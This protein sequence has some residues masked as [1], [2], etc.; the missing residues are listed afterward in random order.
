MG[1]Y[2]WVIIEKKRTK[3]LF[4]VEIYWLT[5][6]ITSVMLHRCC[7]GTGTKLGRALS[8]SS[9]KMVV[10]YCREKHAGTLWNHVKPTLALTERLSTVILSR[11]FNNSRHRV[12]RIHNSKRFSL[13]VRAVRIYTYN[14]LPTSMLYIHKRSTY[15]GSCIV[16]F[17]TV[18]FYRLHK[19]NLE[20]KK[21]FIKLRLFKNC[22]SISKTWFQVGKTFMRELISSE[23]ASVGWSS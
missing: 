20:E 21:K 5:W 3:I 23:S 19:V 11:Y 17:H 8:Q 9:D 12:F 10:L 16:R 2:V 1:V 14:Y 4:E 7:I 6:F 18:N 22:W 13:N 15:T